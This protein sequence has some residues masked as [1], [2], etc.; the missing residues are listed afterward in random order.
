MRKVWE[1]KGQEHTAIPN[2]VREGKE[3]RV[4]PLNWERFVTLN[5]DSQL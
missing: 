2:P 3:R 5:E 4:L 1:I